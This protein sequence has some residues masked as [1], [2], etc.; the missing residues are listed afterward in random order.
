MS[1]ENKTNTATQPDPM[2]SQLR[3]LALGEDNGKDM[4]EEIAKVDAAL[5]GDQRKGTPAKSDG[6]DT[7]DGDESDTKA[8]EK[9]DSTKK[10]GTEVPSDQKDKATAKDGEK[11]PD[12]KKEPTAYEKAQKKSADERARL[13]K[14]WKELQAQRAAIAAERAEIE[15]AKAA[16]EPPAQQKP[17]DPLA[18]F[19]PEQLDKQA[20]VFERE[21]RYDMAD[22]ARKVAAE[23]RAAPPAAEKQPPAGE[24][25]PA[26]EGPAGREQFMAE[27]NRNVA[28]L[29]ATEV[30]LQDPGTPL[31]KETEALIREVPLLSKMADGV[32][33]AVQ[34]AKLRIEAS[35]VPG[36]KGRIGELEKEIKT[37]REATS[38]GSGAPEKR[39]GPKDIT[40]MSEAEAVNALRS[41]AAEADA[42]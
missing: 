24:P 19:T 34:I 11:Q 35:S 40:Q 25:R 36:L 23:K 18:E 33:Y 28:E 7:T 9:T 20:A 14:S 3:A 8:S 26:A 29:K 38:L 32:K 5:A 13:D 37:L 1:T 16:K 4:S 6:G 15:R 30:D 2:E 17:E 12:A 42:A 10:P 39:G 41:L 31:Y 27:W 21:G 22:Y